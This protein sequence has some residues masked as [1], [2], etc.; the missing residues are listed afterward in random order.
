MPL[1]VPL[2]GYLRFFNAQLNTASSKKPSRYPGLLGSVLDPPLSSFA[3]FYVSPLS[4]ETRFRTH[5]SARETLLW[6]GVGVV[7]GEP[8]TPAPAP[9]P[10]AGRRGLT[11]AQ[12]QEEPQSH[13]GTLHGAAS[14]GRAGRGFWAG[15]GFCLLLGPRGSA[16]AALSLS[17]LSG[18]GLQ[19][20]K[21]GRGVLWRRPRL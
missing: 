19:L 13:A 2:L 10:R 9:S 15:R 8:R 14:W 7:A 11:S 20:L 16:A 17:F 18:T 1:P 4:W 3:P 21:S 6:L 12:S 5:F